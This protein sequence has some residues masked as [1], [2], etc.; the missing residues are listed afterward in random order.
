[1]QTQALAIIGLACAMAAQGALPPE[2][3]LE[4]G[5]Y[6]EALTAAE[7][8]DTP[9]ARDVRI[10]AWLALLD[11]DE[12]P[13]VLLELIDAHLARQ[14]AAFGTTS[15]EYGEAL[16]WRGTARRSMADVVQ[17]RTI[18]AG[19][20]ASTCEA[21]ALGQQGYLLGAAGRIDEARQRT[22]DAWAMHRARLGAD[23]PVTASVE[24]SMVRDCLEFGGSE[25]REHAEH[26]VEA[27][28]AAAPVQQA[29]LS[30]ALG[31]LA[32]VRSMA[33]DHRAALELSLDALRLGE[34]TYGASSTRLLTTLG[35]LSVT[36]E[37]LGDQARA[38]DMAA[39]AVRIAEERLGPDHVITA[40][41]LGTLG[42]ELATSGDLPAAIRAV[43][44]A[45]AIHE[46]TRPDGIELAGSLTALG[47]L[48]IRTGDFAAA[49]RHLLRAERLFSSTMGADSFR[50]V[51]VLLRLGEAE[52]AM[53]HPGD[54]LAHYDQAL[55]A[56]R[57][58]AAGGTT[59][60]D[61][62][63]GRAEALLGT[64]R[65][66]E[67]G[68]ALTEVDR[69]SGDTGPTRARL[70]Q[71]QAQLALTRRHWADALAHGQAALADYRAIDGRDSADALVPLA[72]TAAAYDALGRRDEALDTALE[73]EHTRQQVQRIVAAGL[74][75][76][77]AVAMKVQR[78][79][80]LALL[81]KRATAEPA[82]AARVW[83]T[84]LAGHA[85]VLDAVAERARLSRTV[86]D[87]ALRAQATALAER[88][89]ALARAVVR[90]RA[91]QA[92]EAYE[93]QLRGLRERAEA[94]ELELAALSAP[95]RASRADAQAG[96]DEV[97][98]RLPAGAA[99]V[100]F[101]RTDDRYAAFITRGR[102]AVAVDLG[103]AAVVD[104]RVRAWRA[105]ITREMNAGGR[106]AAAN[107][108]RMRAAGRS[109]R[110]AVWDPLV[111]ATTGA[112]RIFIVPDGSL[113]TVN[114]A[115]LP[116]DA[117][118]YLVDSGPLLHVLT[119]ERDLLTAP[120]DETGRGLLAVGGAAF[121]ASST[122]TAARFRGVDDCDALTRAR[123]EAL[124]G[125]A[126]EVRGVMAAW[127][128]SGLGAGQTLTGTA[129]TKEAVTAQSAG[130]RVL[131]FA[132]HGF[133]V[134]QAC[135]RDGAEALSPLLR[136]GLALAGANDPRA[137]ERGILTAAE[138]AGLDLDGTSW[139]VLSG[140]DTG[141]GDVQVGEGVLGLRRAF[142]TAGVRSVVASLWPVGDED[143]R[144]W[145]VSL[146]DA[147]FVRHRDTAEA[148][149]DASRARL[150]ARRAAGLSTHPFYWA[151]F[152]AV[153][154]WR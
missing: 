87:S 8:S 33:G 2:A 100:A 78:P 1:M 75:E 135:E 117:G 31:T 14:A 34:A 92:V 26:A 138:I 83:S 50:V 35:L 148:V 119:T 40:I 127:R 9:S 121:D 55:R 104:R 22:A 38:V 65:D 57:T 79:L 67:A 30:A 123:F 153:G 25:C 122:P 136:A 56:S 101:V 107:E 63:L 71:L 80:T 143:T 19:H 7:T 84:I 62:L 113:S 66:D 93:Q 77:S 82:V 124:P 45:V 140:C 6:R 85:L 59:A 144:P 129:A 152:V 126:L 36:Y 44:R 46:R 88:R 61:A 69:L 139:A 3:L 109:L 47:D 131:H 134:P 4:R 16:L 154:D 125:S 68:T 58:Q 97:A 96:F 48:S 146:Y 110:V 39:R 114:F 17:A 99:L 133:F 141:T 60:Q 15:V 147:H 86:D 64:G 23:H 12:A 102:A 95:F 98:R 132:T 130:R 11:V 43:S 29:Y 21:D 94:A 128:T 150:R 18:C 118:G 89:A 42:M 108:A 70:R 90:G 105:G 72:Q 149:R 81:V 37:S 49:R 20:V 24:A 103:P 151:G 51:H 52:L 142:L 116:T 41:F 115:A 112:E 120:A 137:R 106:S 32:R 91:A 54:A 145:M 10:K 111:A 5:Q 74:P 53:G 73:V 28:R 27:L 13:P 76:R